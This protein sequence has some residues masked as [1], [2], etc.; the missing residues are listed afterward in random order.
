MSDSTY[1]YIYI[2]NTFHIAFIACVA[3]VDPIEILP[4][5]PLYK[6]MENSTQNETTWKT[7]MAFDKLSGF[8]FNQ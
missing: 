7:Y 1:I 6:I 2:Y 4:Y 5:V 3:G 8:L